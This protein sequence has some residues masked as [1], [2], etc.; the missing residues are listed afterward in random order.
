MRVM[1]GK[2][3][4]VGVLGLVL[5]FGVACQGDDEPPVTS[6]AASPAVA[7][8]A[9]IESASVAAAVSAVTVARVIDGD[10]F[11]LQDGTKVRV[12]GIDSC[13]MSTKGGREAKEFAE[14]TFANQY[15]QPVTL[16]AQPGVD[17]DRY[18][19]LLRYVQLAGHDYGEFI[20]GYD[21]TGVYQGRNDASAEYVAK[22]RG[23]D[24][25]GRNCAGTPDVGQAGYG[26]S[27]GDGD[28]GESRFCRK[29][30]WC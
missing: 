21:H 23:M 3:R 26:S 2:G 7:G 9:P 24:P 28:D 30:R 4:A 17:R 18:G 19:R 6:V 22:L 14:S 1:G 5:V 16:S 11:A 15:N 29:R 13:E 10:T 27:G 20:V 8:V 12:L 25:E